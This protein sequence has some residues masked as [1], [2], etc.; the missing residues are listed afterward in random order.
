MAAKA[1]KLVPNIIYIRF[2]KSSRRQTFLNNF[3]I[4]LLSLMF[5][6]RSVRPTVKI[7]DILIDRF[8]FGLIAAV[9]RSLR[10]ILLRNM[11]STLF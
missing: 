10:S 1:L 11:I 7:R 6:I 2:E 9:A 4:R 8:A 5:R 3:L